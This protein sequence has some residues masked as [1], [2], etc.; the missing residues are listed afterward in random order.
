METLILATYSFFCWLI[1][2]VFKVPVNKWTLTTAV[3]GGFFLI[4]SVVIMMN[5]NHP[6]T[7]NARTYFVSTPIIT[8]VNSE[9]TSVNVKEQEHV[10]K[11]DTLFTLDSTVFASR[12]RTLLASRKL[13]RTRLKQS[14][15][16]ARARAGSAYDVERY[17]AEIESY[18]AQ[19]IEAKYNLDECIVTAPADGLIAQAR[20]RPGMRAVQFPLAP[21]MTLVDTNE[22][23]V[24]AAI[25]QNPIQRLKVGNEA[26][27]IFD[28]LPGKIIKGEVMKIG[29]VLQQGELQ[30]SG[31][32]VNLDTPG[33]G[34]L[35]GSVPIRI[36]LTSDVSEYFIP[37]GAKCQVAI[38]SDY[39]HHVTPVRKMLL[40]MKGWMN[41]LFGEH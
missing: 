17:T 24:I 5:Y 22:Y 23:Y 34:H 38:Y 20:L 10:K 30:A 26:E 25:P 8:N 12:Y 11:G 13:A 16:L 14:Q 6:Y 32:M 1:F 3:L 9:V 28:A 33:A 2:K 27:V 31:R 4:A 35:Q 19:L 37:G 40:R 7:S 18:N 29:E 39:M 36:K 21:L 15:Q 41:Y